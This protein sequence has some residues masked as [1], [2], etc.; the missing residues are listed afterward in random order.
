MHYICYVGRGETL[1]MVKSVTTRRNSSVFI[2]NSDKIEQFMQPRWA[3]KCF[4]LVERTQWMMKNFYFWMVLIWISS[5]HY[6]FIEVFSLA[7][8]FFNKN[9]NFSN[10]IVCQIDEVKQWNLHWWSLIA[11]SLW[12]GH[13]TL[14]T[15]PNQ[16]LISAIKIL[17]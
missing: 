3:W 5:K 12:L 10:T 6:F 4:G 17:K 2:P 1:S 11:S 8:A 16:L 13:D 15:R 9:R 14:L 7:G